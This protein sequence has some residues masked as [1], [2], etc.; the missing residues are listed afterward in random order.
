[1]QPGSAGPDLEV[2][3]NQRR[4]EPSLLRGGQ[5]IIATG[6]AVRPENEPGGLSE[7]GFD[8]AVCSGGGWDFGFSKA[9]NVFPEILPTV[10]RLLYCSVKQNHN[11]PRRQG[12][13]SACPAGEPRARP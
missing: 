1:M 5:E 3:R 2:L 4:A 10:A 9:A 11:E 13:S 8:R 6:P 7:C 12:T